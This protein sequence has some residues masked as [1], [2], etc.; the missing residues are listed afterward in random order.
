[1]LDLQALA[2]TQRSSSFP[3]HVISKLLG[4]G[5]RR[6]AHVCEGVCL[7]PPVWLNMLDLYLSG[8][9]RLQTG[10]GE[11]LVRGK[12][13]HSEARPGLSHPDPASHPV[14]LGWPAGLLR[15]CFHMPAW[16]SSH[17][18]P[19]L[20]SSS[21]AASRLV[22]RGP[23]APLGGKDTALLCDTQAGSE[24]SHSRVSL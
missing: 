4:E 1:M 24:Q 13:R 21:P 2:W 11:T 18:S 19:P 16:W 22:G 23:V 7:Y 9:G 14:I 3:R 8:M 5:G 12:G 10:E 20:S 17:G 6:E 15:L